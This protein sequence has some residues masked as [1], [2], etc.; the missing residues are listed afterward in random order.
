MTP[1][2]MNA[3]DQEGELILVVDD[4]PDVV[5]LIEYILE[6]KGYRVLTAFSG[7][8]ALR[9]AGLEPPDLM[10]VDLM[11][12]GM[13]GVELC[14]RVRQ[15]VRLRETPILVLTALSEEVHEIESLDAGADDYVTKPIAPKLFLSHVRALIRRLA[16]GEDSPATL[17]VGDLFIDRARYVVLQGEEPNGSEYQLPR[18]EFDL[19]YFLAS[20]PGR[21]FSRQ[22]LLDQVWGSDVYVID[23]TVDVH[24]RKIR[25]KIGRDYIQTIRGRGYR[26]TS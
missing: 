6:Q 8:E 22:E 3:T 5:A 12:P 23:R 26:F 24:V 2:F 18:K 13:D 1:S 10:V 11:M 21:V 16:R 19:L 25:E 15:D 14:R 4:D 7:Q 9:L 17:Q 20:H